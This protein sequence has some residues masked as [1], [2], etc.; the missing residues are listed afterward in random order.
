MSHNLIVK[1][2][3]NVGF[4]MLIRYHHCN[5]LLCWINRWLI[6]HKLLGS[7]LFILVWVPPQQ[8]CSAWEMGAASTVY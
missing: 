7:S 5:I 2:D 4:C 8:I 3:C 1:H 6:Y